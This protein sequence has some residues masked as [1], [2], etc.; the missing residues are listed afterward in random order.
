MSTLNA[1]LTITKIAPAILKAQQAMGDAKKDSKNPFFKSSYADLNSIREV[2]I[3]ALNA[4]GVAVLQPNITIDGKP[5]VRTLLL[6]ES[7]EWIAGDTEI[8]SLKA[9]DPQANGSG[10]SYARRY[11]LQ[12]LLNIG[13][14]DDDAEGSMGRT[15]KPATKTG[16]RPQHEKPQAETPTLTN[17]TKQDTTLVINSQLKDSANAIADLAKAAN[18]TEKKSFRKTNVE[19]WE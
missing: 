6:H 3:P 14:V 16:P 19:G 11:G 7:G 12:S 5:H 18:V 2:A 9:G 13:A 17:G 8:L 15:T 10:I 1:S 4:Q